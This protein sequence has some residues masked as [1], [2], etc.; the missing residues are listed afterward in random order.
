MRTHQERV[1][2]ILVRL[3]GTR[4]GVDDLAQEVF[5][6]LFRGLAH[7]R[8]DAQV[9][10][11]LYRIIVNVAHDARKRR[12]REAVRTVSL[13]DSAA[14]SETGNSFCWEDR[15]A[16]P[17]PSAEQHLQQREFA[18]AVEAA[19]AQLSSPERAVL[20]LYHQEELSYDEIAKALEMP[21]NTVRT[22]LHRG[23]GKL[24]GMLTR[25]QQGVRV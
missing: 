4:D 15:L 13:N 12:T 17:G 1:F 23:R 21:V 10:T 16:H 8:G 2:R 20:V 11:Y 3:L 22:H 14:S 7:F 6:R 5:L 18:S 24:R 19:L 9:E 25:A